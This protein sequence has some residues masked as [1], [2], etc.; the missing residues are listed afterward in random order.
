MSRIIDLGSCIKKKKVL[1]WCM[2]VCL[3]YIF[4]FVLLGL[5]DS[6]RKLEV[7]WEKGERRDKH[8]LS[9]FSS[10]HLRLLSLC[11]LYILEYIYCIFPKTWVWVRFVVFRVYFILLF[12]LLAT[13]NQTHSSSSLSPRLSSSLLQKL[14]FLLSLIISVDFWHFLSTGFYVLFSLTQLYHN[15]C[16]TCRVFYGNK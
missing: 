15:I 6:S 5:S 7:E 8:L 16:R 2:C 14:L 9:P 11:I 4:F 3:Y 1:I 12:Q 10:V 13:F